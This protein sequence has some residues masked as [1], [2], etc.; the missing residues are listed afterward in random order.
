M[1]TLDIITFTIG[2]SLGLISIALG[3]F[4]IW[5]SYKLAQSSNS[6]LDSV[7]DLARETKILVDASLS[8]QKDFSTKMLDSILQQNKFG[9]LKDVSEGAENLNTAVTSEITKI[10]EIFEQNIG[11]SI[12]KTVQKLEGSNPNGH[13]ELKE[14]LE[15]IQRDIGN[16]SQAAPVITSVVNGSDE[17]R[18]SL[19]SFRDYPAHYIVLNGIIRGGLRDFDDSRNVAEKYDFPD[20]WQDGVENLIKKGVLVYDEDGDGFEVPSQYRALLK[21]WVER[22]DS[23]ITALRSVYK[24]RKDQGPSG[25][26]QT[27]I[28]I[29]SKFEH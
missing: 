4:A 10:L 23:K 25:P 3:L 27:E 13:V 11:S 20:E 21:E 29:G 22:N 12:E 6:A 5:F 14:A 16:L 17:L 8:Q 26:S 7:K 15:A 1:E 24:A 18:Q 28:L 2:V 19:Q 9:N